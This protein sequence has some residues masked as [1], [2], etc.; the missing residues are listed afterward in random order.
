[1]ENS[2]TYRANLYIKRESAI[3][4]KDAAYKTY[5]NMGNVVDLLIENYLEKLLEDIKNKKI[6]P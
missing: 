4:L 1:M 3:K 2:E 6:N 5:S